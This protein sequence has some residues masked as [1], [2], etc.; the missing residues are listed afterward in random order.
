M[1]HEQKLRELKNVQK[2]LGSMAQSNQI[3]FIYLLNNQTSI[4]E[5]KE[6]K[7]DFTTSKKKQ[8]DRSK[9]IFE[10]TTAKEYDFILNKKLL[11]T[12]GKLAQ[13]GQAN[14]EFKQ[15]VAMN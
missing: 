15:I 14:R 6:T 8:I 13:A 11:N 5:S 12:G 9:I 10:E 3:K 1:Q 2:E 4:K 7:Q